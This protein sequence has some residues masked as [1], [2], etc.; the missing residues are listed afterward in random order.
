MSHADFP[1]LH[2]VRLFRKMSPGDRATID[3]LLTPRTV[4]SGTTLFVHGEPGDAMLIVARGRVGIFATVHDAEELIAE[5]S[6][7]EFVG[8]MACIDPAP[9]SATVRALEEAVVFE[10]SRA[11]FVR[12][13][14]L[15][16]GAAAALTGEIILEVTRRLRAVDDKIERAVA[17]DLPMSGHM[18]VAL[19]ARAAETPRGAAPA[20]TKAPASTA[21]PGTPKSA[22]SDERSVWQR[23][24]SAIR[25]GN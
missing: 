21:S 19:P 13:R 10:L 8:E 16:P 2:E 18:I 14:R 4:Q 23:F 1:A 5:I 22:N 11:N 25:G 7:G 15:S 24:V 17:G 3:S 12:L 20:S 6:A 9:R